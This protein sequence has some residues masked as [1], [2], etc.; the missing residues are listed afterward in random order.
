MQRPDY[1]RG[2]LG[3]GMA[4]VGVGA[5]HRCH[6][7]DY[8]DDMLA[9]RFGRWG[10]IGVSIR[11]PRLGPTLGAQGGLYTRLLREGDRAEARVIGNM[12]AVVDA[13][14]DPVP[15][16]EVL[17]APEIEVVTLTVTEK[18]YCHRPATGA[19]DRGHPDVVHDLA[20][21]ETPR[22]LPG[23]LARALE[24]RMASHRRPVTLMSC[25]NIPANGTLLAGVVGAMARTA[26]GA[27][28][29]DRAQRGVSL[30]DGRPDRAGDDAG[31]HR[32]RGGSLRLSRRGGGDRRALPAVGDRGPFRRAPA[33]LGSGGRPV[34]RRT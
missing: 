24:V 22:S 29:L 30:D 2:A 19:L 18:G 7:A 14:G 9:R 11:P 23:I 6:Q 4:H 25:D 13:Q 31:R 32:G 1:D 21:P 27:G 20:H 16:I 3:A 17:A 8:T 5:F 15:A 26:A 10:V 28:G 12:V 33:G 34:R